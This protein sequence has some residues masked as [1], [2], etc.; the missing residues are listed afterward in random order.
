MPDDTVDSAALEAV[1]I[2]QTYT[3]SHGGGFTPVYVSTG[4]IVNSIFGGGSGG[5]Q[6]TAL[7]PSAYWVTL[8]AGRVASGHLLHWK[9]GVISTGADATGD[10]AS[11]VSGAPVNYYSDHFGPIQNAEGHGE[12]YVAGD[13]GHDQGPAVWWTVQPTD[14]ALD[15]SVT[16]AFLYQ[17]S[18]SH[19]W[20]HASLPCQVDIVNFG[21][22]N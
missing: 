2:A 21:P 9:S 17:P 4:L 18:G 15:G 13:Y 6:P 5:T 8:P 12:L 16:L 11:V 20:G 7:A 1:R 14:L 10:L 3:D 19:R 22:H